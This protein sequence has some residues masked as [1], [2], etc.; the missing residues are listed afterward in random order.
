M[1]PV[2]SAALRQRVDSSV[3]CREDFHAPDLPQLL[4]VVKVLSFAVNQGK[5][6]VH[7]HAGLGRTGALIACF[8]V[9][10]ERMNPFTA[11]RHVR[12][13][14]CGAGVGLMEGEREVLHCSTSWSVSV[15][16][17]CRPGSIQTSVQ[18]EVVKAFS[19]YLQPL[20]TIFP[21]R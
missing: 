11:I 19:D 9:F 4:D 14:R 7:C 8:L 10:Q 12:E 2:V 16:Y 3:C 6:A 1:H 13:K 21:S 15:L 20:W 17:V 5:A 18:V